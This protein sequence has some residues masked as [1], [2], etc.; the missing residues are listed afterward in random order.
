MYFLSLKNPKNFSSYHSENSSV[1]RRKIGHFTILIKI[2]DEN[3][4]MIVSNFYKLSTFS[5]V[6]QPFYTDE[7]L[8]SNKSS[9]MI[10][11]YLFVEI[12]ISDQCSLFFF[13]FINSE[14]IC[15]AK[16][17]EYNNSKKYI[18][19]NIPRFSCYFINF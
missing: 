4:E 15:G 6:F 18:I 12:K 17:E 10:S 2:S 11:K 8:S 7:N 9:I 3:F 16:T 13:K 5:Q 14:S 19:N 1:F